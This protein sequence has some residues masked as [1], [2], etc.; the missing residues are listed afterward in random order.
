M[1]TVGQEETQDWCWGGAGTWPG[2][3]GRPAGLAAHLRHHEAV[4]GRANT[5][6]LDG[7]C[8]YR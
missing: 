2:R 3:D 1:V 4:G 8:V 5:Q 6:K 7:A